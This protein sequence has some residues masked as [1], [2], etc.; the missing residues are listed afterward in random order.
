LRTTAHD[1]SNLRTGAYDRAG[2]LGRWEGRAQRDNHA[3]R[4]ED[5][6]KGDGKLRTVNEVY[7]DAIPLLDA[8]IGQG[9]GQPVAQLPQ[10]AIAHLVI[11]APHDGQFQRDDAGH[12]IAVA[13]GLTVQQSVKWN[14]RIRLKRVWHP[15]IV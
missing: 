3:A 1:N 15:L 6:K 7:R 13:V 12:A 2:F 4:L 5:A 11:D 14:F 9:G 10:F 8:H